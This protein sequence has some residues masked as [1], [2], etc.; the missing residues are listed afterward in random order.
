MVGIQQ[1]AGGGRSSFAVRVGR[2][3]VRLK[4]YS[5]A[6]ATWLGDVQV[7]V[8]LL[9]GLETGAQSGAAAFAVLFVAR[10]MAGCLDLERIHATDYLMEFLGKKAPAR[11]RAL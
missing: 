1:Q 3:L 9:V 11:V 6:G 4:A 2:F 7:V 10:I 5:N 8:P